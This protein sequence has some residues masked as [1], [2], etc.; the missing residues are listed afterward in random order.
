MKQADVNFSGSQSAALSLNSESSNISSAH[1]V[2]VIIKK[3]RVARF[4]LFVLPV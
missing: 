3:F 2:R 4:S 1:F